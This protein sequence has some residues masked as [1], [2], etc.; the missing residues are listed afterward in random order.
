MEDYRVRLADNKSYDL[1]RKTR[2]NPESMDYSI[3]VHYVKTVRST[4]EEDW[5]TAMV[6][7]IP[8]IPA[9]ERLL[10]KDVFRNCYGI[11]LTVKYKDMNYYIDPHNVEYDGYEIMRGR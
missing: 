2:Y 5:K 8:D 7:H 1:T 10:V 3:M 6:H 4:R 9:G 11:W